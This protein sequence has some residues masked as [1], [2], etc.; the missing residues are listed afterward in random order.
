MSSWLAYGGVPD[1]PPERPRRG[2]LALAGRKRGGAGKTRGAVDW[3]PQFNH[4]NL[5]RKRCFLPE[6]AALHTSSVRWDDLRRLYAS[7]RASAGLPIERVAKFMGHADIA[8][9]YKHYLHPFNHMDRLAAAASRRALAR[10]GARDDAGAHR[11]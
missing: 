8:T 7:A 10:I 4:D 11:M 1:T 6:L 2:R 3:C 9:M 5:Y